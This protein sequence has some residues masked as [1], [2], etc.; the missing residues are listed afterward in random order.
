MV[1]NAPVLIQLMILFIYKDNAS[2][3]KKHLTLYIMSFFVSFAKHMLI[4]KVSIVKT[5]IDVLLCLIITVYG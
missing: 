1:F 5:V 4:K 2:Q 3:N